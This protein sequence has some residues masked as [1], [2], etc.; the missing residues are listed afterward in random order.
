MATRRDT[1]QHRIQ[2][3]GCARCADPV[4]VANP[5][6]A[7][8]LGNAIYYGQDWALQRGRPRRGLAPHDT[9]QLDGEDATV[10][11]ASGR[12][13]PLI[14]SRHDWWNE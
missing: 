7:C 13:E 12:M 4:Q 10:G 6:P 1:R 9:A 14:E 11:E 8:R 5:C 3:H 2:C